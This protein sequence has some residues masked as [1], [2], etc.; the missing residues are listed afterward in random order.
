[1]TS[2]LL[3]I[4]STSNFIALPFQ[5]DTFQQSVFSMGQTINNSFV[6][7]TPSVV[8]IFQQPVSGRFL[9]LTN[10]PIDIINR[11]NNFYGWLTIGLLLLTFVLSLNWY[12]FPERM[13][14]LLSREGSKHKTKY[15]NNQFAKPGIILYSLLW[16]TFIFTTGLFIYLG[17]VQFFPAYISEFSFV[18]LMLIIPA[19]IVLYYLLRYIIIITSGFLFNTSDL[20]AK[21]IKAAFRANL[22]QGFLLIPLLFVLLSGTSSYFYYSGVILLLIIVVYKWGISLYIGVKSSKISVYHNILYL[23]TLEIVPVIA[24]LKLL[25]NYRLYLYN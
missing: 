24:L 16:F 15:E 7:T 17:A 19:L 1:M 3:H 2:H 5:S 21:Q 4:D 14:R 23:C 10:L 13:L 12:F 25:D 20:A 11:N 18:R 6:D 9:Q 8:S 22:I